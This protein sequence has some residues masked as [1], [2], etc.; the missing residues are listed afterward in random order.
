MTGKNPESEWMRRI[1]IGDERAF[2]SLFRAYYGRLVVFARKY[3]VDR[4]LA[5][6]LVQA[7]FVK[8]WEKRTVLNIEKP[9]AYLMVAVRNH[10][11]N[12]L[13][14][15]KIMV[16]VDSDAGQLSDMTEEELP[17]EELI[18]KVHEV[19]SEMP[20]Q[21]KKIFYMNRFEG[22]KYK[23][24][25]KN[26]GLSVKTIEAQMGKALRF[27]REKLPQVIESRRSL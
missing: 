17:S 25:A 12:E 27:L 18:D 23:D 19:I 13:K 15:Q 16:S 4:D 26:M 20:P 22:M 1:V 3:I 10:C 6:S 24:I 7:V 9:S 2:E 8:L 11:L 21:R 14:Q 5:E